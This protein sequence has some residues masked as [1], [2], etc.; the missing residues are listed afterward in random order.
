MNNGICAMHE[1]GAKFD[2][3]TRQ[4]S[5]GEDSSPDAVLRLEVNGG[6]AAVYEFAHRENA[7]RP[8]ADDD[9]IGPIRQPAPAVR[10][11]LHLDVIAE[12]ERPKCG[13]GMARVIS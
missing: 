12:V 11:A 1:F 5:P 3:V 6:A 2:G 13:P 9:D 7:G 4:G 8:G 10:G